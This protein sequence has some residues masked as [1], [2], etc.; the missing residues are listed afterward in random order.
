MQRVSIVK[1]GS[2]IRNSYII[3]NDF[4]TSSI[5]S[6]SSNALSIGEN[7]TIDHAIIDKSAHRKKRA[8]D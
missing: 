4:Y 2:I 1:Q 3:G 8:V 5:Q 6:Q 7:C